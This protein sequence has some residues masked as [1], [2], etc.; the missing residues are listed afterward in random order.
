MDYEMT[1]WLYRDCFCTEWD[2]LYGKFCNWFM[3]M[4][5]SGYYCKGFAQSPSI[6]DYS[7]LKLRQDVLTFSWLTILRHIALT[8]I[9]NTEFCI[10]FSFKPRTQSLHFCFYF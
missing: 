3:D 7:F 6:I 9:S 10:K 4:I 8:T 5:V 2:L 1:N